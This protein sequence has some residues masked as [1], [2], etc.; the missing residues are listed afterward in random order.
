MFICIEQ[1][2]IILLK[3]TVVNFD[4]LFSMCTQ[5]FRECMIMK[6]FLKVI[7]IYGYKCVRTLKTS[8]V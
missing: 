2:V 5:S 4:V 8:N 7:E 6:M 1:H 3:Y